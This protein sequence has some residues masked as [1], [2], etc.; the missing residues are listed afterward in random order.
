MQRESRA[1]GAHL[2]GCCRASNSWR[3]MSQVGRNRSPP[4]A[5]CSLCQGHYRSLSE[6]AVRPPQD[7]GTRTACFQAGRSLSNGL[8]PLKIIIAGT[9]ARPAPNVSTVSSTSH[10]CASEMRGTR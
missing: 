3:R 7:F 9:S 4:V 6:S 5:G 10:E 1:S 8:D 2:E